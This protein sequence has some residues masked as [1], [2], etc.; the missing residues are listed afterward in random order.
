[1]TLTIDYESRS[2]ADLKRVGAIAYAMDPST[3]VMC[4][5]VKVDDQSP[6]LWVP[7]CWV[8][9]AEGAGISL[10]DSLQIGKLVATADKIEAHN[11]SFELA[12]WEH[13]FSP[14]CEIVDGISY[15]VPPLPLAKMRCSAAK[16]AMHA[17]PRALGECGAAL[18]WPAVQKDTEGYVAMMRL[19]KPYKGE[20]RED[21]D[22]LVKMFKY[23]LQDVDA[24]YAISKGLRDLPPLEQEIWQLDQ[25]INARGMY[26]DVEAAKAM[27]AM[28]EQH[29]KNLLEEFSA[30]TKGAVASPRQVAALLKYCAIEGMQG[31][32]KE[33]VKWALEHA[34][35]TPDVRR[36]LEIRQSLAKASVAKYTALLERA[37]PV[38]HR[39]RSCFMYHGASTGRWSGKGF[40][41]HN[42]PR[43]GVSDPD[44]LY[45]AAT[46][47]PDVVADLYGDPMYY[48]SR[49]VRSLITAA[50][51]NELTWADFNAIESRVLNW[52]AG[53]EWALKAYREGRDMYV[54]NAVNTFKIPL[55][56]VGKPQRQV[57]KVE[58]LALGYQGGM[59]AFKR[60]ATGYNIHVVADDGPVDPTAKGH[61]TVTL[62]NDPAIG[63]QIRGRIAGSIPAGAIIITESQ[64]KTAIKDWRE[65]HPKVVKYWYGVE[66]AAKAA[67]RSP[68]V[69][70]KYARVAFVVSAGFLQLRL[71][72]GR[73]L[74]YYNPAIAPK[75]V[76]KEDG[77]TWETEGITFMGS[78]P[79]LGSPTY[80][81]W[82][83]VDTYGGKLTENIVQAVARDL[84]A[85]AMLRIEK[86]SYPIV[87]HVHDE[88]VSEHPIGYGS[89]AAY[90]KLMCEVPTW[91]NGLP[92]AAEGVRARRY[93]K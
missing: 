74:Y 55:E 84:L 49:A 61:P 58:E 80:G 48:A 27:V 1:M 92:I 23:C 79:V 75:T 63:A 12:I 13:C 37:H 59:G 57:G 25:I 81:R 35:I 2:T 4:L 19:C 42:L 46:Q 78:D 24:E 73:I 6:K 16:A 76:Q 33:D 54:L 17:L 31:I 68:G 82:A 62:V 53:E 65:A 29:E 45:K 21:P 18:K 34:K 90:E 91:A 28:T 70:H 83:R 36:L 26:V 51:G 87:L 67:I 85:E 38:D 11:A 47:G 77:T 89:V 10:I 60:M 3:Q 56:K 20:F 43:E 66:N 41:P 93:R 5:A 7:H 44:T 52:E 8:K 64:V 88:C 71:A 9:L 30:I 14:I 22:D 39:M 32:T 50:P 69:V 72:S 15:F 40:Q 86:A